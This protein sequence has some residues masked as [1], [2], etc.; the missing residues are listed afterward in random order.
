[1]HPL[2]L[3]VLL[4][5]STLLLMAIIEDKII[6]KLGENSKFKEW[7]RRNLIGEYEGPDDL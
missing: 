2:V 6:P 3:I 1:M 7:W 5:L 4:G